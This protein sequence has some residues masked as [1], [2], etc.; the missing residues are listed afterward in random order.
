MAPTTHSDSYAD[1]PP[2]YTTLYGVR[3]ALNSDP[4]L[5]L[6]EFQALTP[7]VRAKFA[8]G[9]AQS[10]SDPEVVQKLNQTSNEAAKAIA[11]I[12]T[13]F[14]ELVS[15]LESLPYD[16]DRL[17]KDFEEI[18]QTYRKVVD[19]SRI[20]AIESSVYAKT[21]DLVI[22]N[23]CADPNVSISDRKIRVQKYIDDA[24]E[25]RVKAEVMKGRYAALITD[26]EKFINTFSSWGQEQEGDMDQRI[27]DLQ[28]KLD[29]LANEIAKID[30]VITI[31]W[32]AFSATLG[33]AGILIALFPPAAPFIV[34]AGAVIAEAQVVA[35]IG[36]YGT[37][38]KLQGDRRNIEGQ[39]KD[40]E[41]ELSRL[42][43]TR[44]KLEARGKAD[45]RVFSD[46]ILVLQNVWALA[47][48]DA[49]KIRTWLEEGANNAEYPEYM[50]TRLERGVEA[51]AAMAQY[52]TDYA[53]GIEGVQR[54]F[55]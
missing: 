43:A 11:A 34:A 45:L 26:F 42:K 55:T 17:V 16:K 36:L 8:V 12:D 30:E 14:I 21:F 38:A 33:I 23:Y 40:L 1:Q 47:E 28:N 29:E 2:A 4:D 19:D 32:A 27:K 35:L 10:T 22:V 7:D 31:V 44:A 53:N 13:M 3:Y 15:M 39:I 51:Y 20:L 46:N 41:G 49:K 9:V 24:E 5:A 48:Q 18:K 6:A 54:R 37:K 52:L 50:R 25:I